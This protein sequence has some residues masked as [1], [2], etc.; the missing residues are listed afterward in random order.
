V[1]LVVTPEELGL[2][3]VHQALTTLGLYGLA[4]DELL[5]AGELA[6]VHDAQRREFVPEA[7][8]YRPALRV[9]PLPTTATD[10]DSWALRG[11][12]LYRDGPVIDPVVAARPGPGERELRL[13]IPFLDPRELD[14]AIASE[15]IVVR[16]GNLR[17]HLLLPGVAEGG[18]L[19]AKVEGELLRLWVE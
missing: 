7:G 14:V 15:E 16:L 11:A 12:A 9:G 8:R 13:Y 17:R 18:R 3:A 5:V 19:R 1:R 10:R 6:A 2:S 4:S